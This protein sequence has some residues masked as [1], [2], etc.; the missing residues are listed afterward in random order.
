MSLESE[1]EDTLRGT[2]EIARKRGYIATYFLQ[3]LN[4]HGGVETAKRLL[5]KS[6]PQEGLFELWNLGILNESM[7]AVI[8][9][10]LKYQRLFTQEEIN[11]AWR[12][13]EELGYF[14]N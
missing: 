5:A 11:E 10:N 6:E 7:E 9:D 1:F 8:C 13:L 3:M 2:Y 12:R 14:K 4:E